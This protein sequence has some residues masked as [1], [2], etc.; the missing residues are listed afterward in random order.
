MKNFLEKFDLFGHD[1]KFNYERQNDNKYRTRP[2]AI[3]S[4]LYGI[5]ILTFAIVRL[6]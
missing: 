6:A 3:L 2:G 4:I 1:V 5:F